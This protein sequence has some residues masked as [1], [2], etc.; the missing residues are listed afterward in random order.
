MGRGVLELI[1][2]V[3]I[4]FSQPHVGLGESRVLRDRGLKFLDRIHVPCIRGLL[5]LLTA[6]EVVEPGAGFC[7]ERT[8]QRDAISGIQINTKFHDHRA[9]DLR[10]HRGPVGW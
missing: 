6:P 9:G 3:R 5:E 4:S 2:K 10:L 8:L 7:Q 1:A